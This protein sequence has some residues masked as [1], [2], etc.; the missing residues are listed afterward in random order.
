M[1]ITIKDQDG[2]ERKLISLSRIRYDAVIKKNMTQIYNRGKAGGTPVD[3]GEL[4]I[5]LSQSGDLVGYTKDYAP[6]VEYGHRT[7]NG[8]FVQGQR[9]LKRNVDAQREIFRQDLIEQ[10]RKC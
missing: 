5:S 7:V 3:T 1:G 2:L 8:G 4:R 6:H 9:F 10:I